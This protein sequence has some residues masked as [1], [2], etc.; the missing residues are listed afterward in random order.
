MLAWLHIGLIGAFVTATSLTL[1]VAVVRRLRV[2]RPL[3]TWTCGPVTC[4]PLGP[5]LFLLL[6]GVGVAYQVSQGGAPPRYV[7][8]GYPVGGLCWWAATWI[9]RTRIVSAYGLIPELSAPERS[10]AWSQIRDYVQTTRDGR[11]YYRFFY[12]DSNDQWQRLDWFVPASHEAAFA[13]LVQEKLDARFAPTEE[14]PSI[15]LTTLRDESKSS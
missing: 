14:L 11:T 7:V 15:D 12:V 9:A 8:L 6:V 10:V 2:R 4:I 13:A 1:S 5:T 3:M